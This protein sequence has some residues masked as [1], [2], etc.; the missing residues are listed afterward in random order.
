MLEFWPLWLRGY[1]LLLLAPLL[2]L[3]WR[4]YRAYQHRGKWELLLPKAMHSA[5]LTTPNPHAGKKRWL[6]LSAAWVVGVLALAGP[7]WQ[8]YEQPAVK[9]YAPLVVILELTQEMLA[10]DGRPTRLAQAKHKILDL[11]K[12]RQDAPTAVV[13]FAGSAHTLVPLTQDQA[14][15]SNLLDALSP[16]IMPVLGHRPDLA[17]THAQAL[18]NQGAQGRGDILLITSQLSEQSL[19]PLSQQAESLTR[20]LKILG[21]GTTEGAP[22]LNQERGFVRDPQGAIRVAKLDHNR[23]KAFAASNGFVYQRI[24]LDDSDLARLKLTSP[25]TV[26]DNHQSRTLNIPLDQGYWLVLV[27]LV[28]A[29]FAGRRGLLLGLGLCLWLPPSSWAMSFDDLWLRS[30]QQASR[31]LAQQRPLEAA[32][33]FNDPL[34]K[35]YALYQAGL[36]HEAAQVFAEV[37]SAEA[38]YNRGTA[39]AAAELYEQALSALNEA[40]ALDPELT[41]AKQNIAAIEHFLANRQA[42]EPTESLPRDISPG[43]SGSVDVNT[44]NLAQP[45]NQTDSSAPA[46][47]AMPTPSTHLSQGSESSQSLEQW[48]RQVPDNPGELLQRKFLMELQQRQGERP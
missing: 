13:V 36:Y 46:N 16:N 41:R 33:H 28:L 3:T 48:L 20:P 47:T 45:Q 7:S 35:G 2:W 37:N 40:L 23:L 4:K 38:H 42:N 43:L 15:I 5:L 19:R 12:L 31:A 6:W 11:L 14:T 17:L 1:W 18:L 24:R 30:D 29:A 27:L 10:Q 8:H 9:P 32:K 39:L 25:S 22:I 34:W 26:T 44:S 21:V